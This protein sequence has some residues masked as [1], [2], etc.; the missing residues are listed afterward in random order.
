MPTKVEAWQAINGTLYG[1][2]GEAQKAEHE[3]LRQDARENLAKVF[4]LHLV[5]SIMTNRKKIFAILHKLN[6]YEQAH[7]EEPKT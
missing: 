5:E 6:V 2:H 3:I 4:P 7:N 1:S